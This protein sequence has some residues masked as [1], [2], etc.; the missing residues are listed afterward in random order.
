M[1]YF[2]KVANSNFVNTNLRYEC[3]LYI[4]NNKYRYSDSFFNCFH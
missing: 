4:N 2:M 3:H 1:S